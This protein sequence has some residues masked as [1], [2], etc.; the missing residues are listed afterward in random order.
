M[1]KSERMA[2]A[3]RRQKFILRAVRRNPQ[4]SMVDLLATTGEINSS[5][6]YYH[7]SR[8]EKAGEKGIAEILHR[9]RIEA[10]ANKSIAA[11]RAGR[12][13]KAGNGRSRQSER[14]RIEQ[15]VEKA[16]NVIPFHD[17]AGMIRRPDG[18]KVVIVK[19]FHWVSVG[20]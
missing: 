5:V 7:L 6:I 2:R 8:L 20:G 4:I 9:L 13:T 16:R 12:I 19:K 11:Q 15:V 18:V 10:R 1:N 17:E 3:K 14:Q